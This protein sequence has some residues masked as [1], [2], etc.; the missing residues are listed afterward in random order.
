MGDEDLN[1]WP[2][3]SIVKANRNHYSTLLLRVLLF[4]G[5]V[6]L[7]LGA[8]VSAAGL[9][10]QAEITL[11]P[12]Q[13]SITPTATP[14]FVNCSA[15]CTCMLE[16][17]ANKEWGTGG[18]VSCSRYPCG[19][20]AV[21]VL[22]VPA[23]KYCYRQNSV[24]AVVITT[25]ASVPV[26][27]HPLQP[28]VVQARYGGDVVPPQEA[29]PPLR[30]SKC[31]RNFISNGLLSQAPGGRV[32]CSLIVKSNDFI[33]TLNIPE[34]TLAEDA[35]KKPLTI[36]NITSLERSEIPSLIIDNNNVIPVHAY[37]CLPDHATFDP[38]VLI[39]F[40]LGQ[41]QWDASDTR[42]LTI[43]ET[44]SGGEKWE[45]LP[46]TLDPATRT[47][48]APVSHFS[49][50]GLFLSTPLVNA[51][52][53]DNSVNGLIRQAVG[54]GNKRSLPLSFLIPDPVAPV[55]AVLFG[56]GVALIGT[57]IT[58]QHAVSR[59]FEKLLGFFKN[60]L[61]VSIV[62][63]ISRKEIEK[64][65]IHPSN[66]PHPLLFGLSGRELRVIGASALLFA[67][68]FLIRD[69]LSLNIVII[70]VYVCVGGIT[71]ILHDLAHKIS[72]RR[73]GCS[74]EYQFWLLGAVTMLLTAGLFGNVFAR[75]AR[76]IIESEKAPTP[77]ENAMIRIA[78][79]LVSMCVA[80]LSLFLIPLGGIFAIA[81]SAGFAFNLLDCVY[82]LLPVTPM[83][84]K[85]VFTW[86]RWVWAAVYFPLII[87][88]L[89]VYLLA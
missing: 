83:D 13:T 37:R 30:I 23:K 27:V 76:T 67:I 26:N 71:V 32:N 6:L 73:C 4:S 56:F 85:D 72:S 2:K 61:G 45:G 52:V 54:S 74:S 14:T 17:D 38:P 87:F 62:G 7:V 50:L 51:T 41:E 25:P 81:G 60:Y 57:T 35:I 34:G 19:E 8:I 58:A 28:Q 10:A 9:P 24:P 36:I 44:S 3:K 79:P 88:Y 78:G 70:I 68:A 64:R 12:I 11:Q 20:V 84:G 49:T 39:T 22:K 18:Y 53:P 47:A 63:M 21:P 65:G 80:I 5:G 86:N 42:N 59:F 16:S 55:A 33:A 66:Q 48:S 89:Y 77:E 40:T 15:P 29:V 1:A 31:T 43:W 75:P 69:R 82:S 46:T